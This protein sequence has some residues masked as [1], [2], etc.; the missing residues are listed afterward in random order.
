MGDYAVPEVPDNNVNNND[1]DNDNDNDN[2]NVGADA[3]PEVPGGNGEAE[4]V[5]GGEEESKPHQGQANQVSL[6]HS[7][8]HNPKNI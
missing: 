2:D 3:V 5:G 6:A 8:N 4:N 1:G 7:Y